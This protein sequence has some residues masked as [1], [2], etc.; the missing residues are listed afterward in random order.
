MPRLSRVLLRLS[1]LR[2]NYCPVWRGISVQFAL[3]WLSSLPW[4]ACPVCRGTRVQF[5]LEYA[6]PANKFK[7]VVDSFH[8]AQAALAHIKNNHCD[9]IISA[10]TLPDM[11]GIKLLS[12]VLHIHPETARI[13]ISEDPGKSTLAQAIN[14]AEVQSL[15]HLHW[16]NSE[17]RSDAR[18]QAWNLHQLKTAAIQALAYRELLLSNARLAALR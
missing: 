7:C 18:R 1:G 16:A 9:L 5:G 15:L 2:W 14:E 11:D 8:S 13:L 6:V 17:L 12:M 3:E 10:Q 4:N